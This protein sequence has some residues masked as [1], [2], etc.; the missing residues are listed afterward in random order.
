[1]F[2]KSLRTAAIVAALALLPAGCPQQRPPVPAPESRDWKPDIAA[3]F[4]RNGSMDNFRFS[5]ELA[6]RGGPEDDA[7]RNRTT[8]TTETATAALAGAL[9]AGWTWDG[10]LHRNPL[11]LEAAVRVAEAPGAAEVVIPLLIRDNQWYASIPLLN[12]PEEYVVI[13]AGAN[14]GASR[15]AV[16]QLRLAGAAA[17]ALA[18]YLFAAADPEWIRFDPADDAGAAFGTFRL[19]AAFDRAGEAVRRGW[20][21]WAGSFPELLR[22]PPLPEFDVVRLAEGGEVSVAIDSRGFVE[23]QRIGL[24]LWKETDGTLS[25]VGRL[26][27]RMTISDINASPAATWTAPTNVLPFDRI[28]RHAVSGSGN[29]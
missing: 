23:Q 7:G 27:Y 9:S 15:E 3:A 16:G 22:P 20:D 21:E 12:E 6:F 28:L 5:G 19:D 17:G 8:E 10:V 25:V 11:R 4:A 1:M 18:G 14:D 26:S 2:F 13:D 24:E 29:D